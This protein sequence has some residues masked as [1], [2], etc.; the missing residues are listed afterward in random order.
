MDIIHTPAGRTVSESESQGS[1]ECWCVGCC[2][3][4][5]GCYMYIVLRTVHT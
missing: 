1:G 5:Q 2:V 4:M 3:Y